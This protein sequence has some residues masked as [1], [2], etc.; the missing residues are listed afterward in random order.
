[1]PSKGP[2]RSRLINAHLLVLHQQSGPGLYISFLFRQSTLQSKN[3]KLSHLQLIGMARDVAGGMTYLSD[4]NFVYRVSI[5]I[6]KM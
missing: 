6:G 1:M 3:S 2:N 5:V 4:M